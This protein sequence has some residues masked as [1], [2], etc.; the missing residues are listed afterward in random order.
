MAQKELKYT[1]LSSLQ[2]IIKKPKLVVLRAKAVY[3]LII[4][5]T[6]P[7]TYLAANLLECRRCPPITPVFSYAAYYRSRFN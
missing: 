1:K 7:P 5:Y 4:K 6:Q 2:H 3:L